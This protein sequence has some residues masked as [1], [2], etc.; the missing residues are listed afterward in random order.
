M[1][2]PSPKDIQLELLCLL[3]G[4]PLTRAFLVKIDSTAIVYHLKDVIKIKKT[5]YFKNVHTSAIKIWRVS[6]P[7]SE[8]ETPLALYSVNDKTMLGPVYKLSEVFDEM[9]EEGTIH[10]I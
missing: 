6:I 8:D 1:S 7:Y 4:E 2:H 5:N 9:P 3:D 10:I